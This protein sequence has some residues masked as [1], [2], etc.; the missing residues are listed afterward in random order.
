[1]LH[2]YVTISNLKFY[3]KRQTSLS[4]QTWVLSLVYLMI[5]TCKVQWWGELKLCD[6][7]IMRK[8]K[9]SWSFKSLICVCVCVCVCVFW[10]NCGGSPGQTCEYHIIY[11]IISYHKCTFVYP[12]KIWNAVFGIEDTNLLRTDCLPTMPVWGQVEAY[13]GPEPL[14]CSTSIT[15]SKTVPLWPPFNQMNCMQE[16][17]KAVTLCIFCC[18]TLWKWLKNI[19][20]F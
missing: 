7:H 15:H 18:V 19:N 13:W 16:S 8:W 20:I 4:S 17:R 3:I 6:V 10:M 1:M 12:R 2:R 9:S 14:V 5:K 11:N